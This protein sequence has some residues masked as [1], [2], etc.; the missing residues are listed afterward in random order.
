MN[1]EMPDGTIIEDVPEGTTQAEIARRYGLPQSTDATQDE[2]QSSPSSPL[3]FTPNT[4]DLTEYLPA[5][6]AIAGG[7]AV[8]GLTVPKIALSTVAA[9]GGAAVGDI[10]QQYREGKGID[11]GHAFDT[12]VDYGKWQLGGSVFFKGLS[13]LLGKLTGEATPAAKEVIEYATKK[14]AP[15]DVGSVGSR[16]GKAAQKTASMLTPG[17]MVIK[18]NSDDIG[19]FIVA[20]AERIAPK[21]ESLDITVSKANAELNQIMTSADD[22]K[23]AAFETFENS[24]GK[25]A[26]VLINNTRKA[27][28]EVADRM[29]K[30]GLTNTMY[31]KQIKSFLEK[32]TNE[33]AVS[34]AE[35]MRKSLNK[36]SY[37]ASK[38]NPG[39][40]E[41]NDIMDDAFSM[42]YDA[43]GA[44]LGLPEQLSSLLGKAKENTIISRALQSVPGFKQYAT[45][46]GERGGAFKHEEWLNGV[47]LP[48][49]A[50][51][52]AILEKAN[53]ELVGEI[54]TAWLASK[55]NKSLI[56]KSAGDRGFVIRANDFD[57]FI[58]ENKH[59]LK[60]YFSPEQ[61][62]ALDNLATYAKY[63]EKSANL[64]DKAVDMAGRGWQVGR[65]MTEAASVYNAPAVSIPAEL[66]AWALAA[67]LTDPKSWVFKVF[68]TGLSEEAITAWS[69]ATKAA[70]TGAQQAAP[71]LWPGAFDG[72]Q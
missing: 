39:I 72:Q 53:P 22:A 56:G 68:T 14:D 63:T 4:T 48:Q 16:T 34:D 61:I 58:K 43:L 41:Y 59:I 19:N 37:N 36:K 18:Q 20:E 31:Y 46:I 44:Q 55:I 54:K 26:P 12:A 7:L 17:E 38:N 29:E 1:V 70:A 49:N 60:A 23:I 47:M 33:M 45:V 65:A 5:A 8:P 62:S 30:S 71:T 25:D 27:A 67:G 2:A 13:G 66:G 10:A 50:K 51:A 9:G 42:D 28:M 24:V 32:G 21:V 69:Q 52:L 64:S 6:G 3:S 57:N 11:I 15:L 40:R 35:I